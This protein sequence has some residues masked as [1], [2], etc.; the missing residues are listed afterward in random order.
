MDELRRGYHD[1]IAALREGTTA[2]V[3]DAA[4]SVGKVTAALLDRDPAAG[5][6]VLTD[7]SEAAAR[8][9]DVEGDV[10]ELLALQA[11]MARDLRVIMAAL[12]V[13]Q[14]AELCL[15]LCRA[16]AARVGR[17]DD[18]L[19]PAL[20][21]LEAGIGAETVRLLDDARAAW[22]VL[23][24]GMA[25][26]VVESASTGRELQRRFLAELF[27]LVD[28]PVDVAV[29]LGMASRAYARLTDHALEIADRVVFAATGGH[30]G[31]VE[32]D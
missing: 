15:G 2:I 27:T 1:R 18:V 31:P 26:A 21:D 22:S 7:A 19:T 25:V 29:D 3:G 9:A 12:R 14:I 24:A 17:G 20:R 10:L 13:A 23:D 11:P 6:V 8:V 16:L 28:V 32:G 30:V 4:A 5:R